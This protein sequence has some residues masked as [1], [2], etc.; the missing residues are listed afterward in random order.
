MIR[1]HALGSA[2]VSLLF[3]HAAFAQSEP[4]ALPPLSATEA[5]SAAPAA[6]P[7]PA[8]TPAVTPAETVPP[9]PL[10]PVAEAAPITDTPSEVDEPPPAT[11]APQPPSSPPRLAMEAGFRMSILPD[12]GFDPYAENDLLPGLSAGA[13]FV[14]FVA[15]PWSFGLAAEYTLGGHSAKARGADASVAIHRVTLGVLARRT[16]GARTVVYGRAAPGIDVIAGSIDDPSLDLPLEV[17]TYTWAIDTSGGVLFTLA[18]PSAEGG[19]GLYFLVEAGY[20]FAGS[21]EMRFAPEAEDD[22]PRLFGATRLPDLSPHGFTNRF[23]LV[24]SFD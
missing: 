12:G 15:G 8:V 20:V 16:L 2:L 22:E 4:P 14:P 18:E 1:P 24:L 9:A 23:G 5:P 3:A 17:D 19:G 11:M 13:L 21:A 6:D 7:A 10:A